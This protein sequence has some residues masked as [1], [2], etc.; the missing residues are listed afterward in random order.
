MNPEVDVNALSTVPK[1]ITFIAA[2]VKPDREELD[3]SHRHTG[4]YLRAG[5]F[6]AKLSGGA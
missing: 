5:A 6:A 2:P 1:S 3:V 4:A